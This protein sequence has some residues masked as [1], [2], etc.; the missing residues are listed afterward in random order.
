MEINNKF[1]IGD[2]FTP[3]KPKEWDR[4]YEKFEVHA[5]QYDRNGQITYISYSDNVSNKDMMLSESQL[6]NHFVKNFVEVKPHEG[7]LPKTQLSNFLELQ[8]SK[9]LS[10]LIKQHLIKGR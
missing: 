10:H 1:N 6:S 4:S 9:S 2:I 3:L 5:I 7:I 8:K